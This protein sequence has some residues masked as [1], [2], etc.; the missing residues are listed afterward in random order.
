[1][2]LAK[3]AV[4]F[5]DVSPITILVSKYPVLNDLAAVPISN[6]FVFD[7]STWPLTEALASST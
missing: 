7:A 4:V 2:L 3:T 5:A 6:S 1:M